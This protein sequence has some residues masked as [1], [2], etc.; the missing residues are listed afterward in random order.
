MALNTS[1]ALQILSC[2]EVQAELM[3]RDKYNCRFLNVCYRKADIPH[4]RADTYPMSVGAGA[5]RLESI[6]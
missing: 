1:P 6:L 4:A 2:P 5:N 3:R